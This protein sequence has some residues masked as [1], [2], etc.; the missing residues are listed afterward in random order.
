MALMQ[1]TSIDEATLA[2]FC[3]RSGIA[4]LEEFDSQFAGF[5]ADLHLLAT[6]TQDAEWSLFDHTRVERELS[7]LLG[8]S[9]ELV[10]RGGV[11]SNP[12]APSGILE[13]ARPF[14]AC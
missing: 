4:K 9:I 10:T 3:E 13:T 1:R 7:E 5:P 14:H 2:A 8:K 12:L 11:E 6:N